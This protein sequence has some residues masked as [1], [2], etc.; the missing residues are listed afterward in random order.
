MKLDKYSRRARLRSKGFSRFLPDKGISRGKHD[1]ESVIIF[2]SLTVA[3]R[4]CRNV[5]VAGRGERLWD[6]TGWFTN[7]YGETLKPAV[8]QIGNVW[9]YGFEELSGVLVFRIDSRSTATSEADFHDEMS[10]RAS[11]A[12]SMTEQAAERERE[13]QAQWQLARDKESE[14]EDLENERSDLFAEARGWIADFRGT[15]ASSG[16]CDRLR[17]KLTE[18][19]TR[20]AEIAGRIRELR[21]EISELP[22]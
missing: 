4:Y 8:A 20:A 22:S 13:Y 9:L 7:D 18:I 3:A 21:A 5:H 2:D 19:R 1:G 11:W 17:G 16:L 6:H 15:V 14:V 12:D 10:D